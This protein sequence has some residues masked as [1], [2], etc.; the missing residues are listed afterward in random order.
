VDGSTDQKSCIVKRLPYADY[1]A[2]LGPDGRVSECGTY[3]DLSLKEGYVSSFS[4]PCPDWNYTSQ[5]K[6]VSETVSIG[7]SPEQK[8]EWSS[9]D[10]HKHTGEFATYSFYLRSIG[11]FPTTTFLIAM[12][13][14]SF[15]ISFPSKPLSSLCE[16]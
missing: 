3:Q 12:A 1:I 9:D 14:F 16:P 11:L 6:E 15:C 10:L 8:V 13:G 4:L 5:S 2:V 7:Y